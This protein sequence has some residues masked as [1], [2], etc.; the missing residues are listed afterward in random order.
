M[1]VLFSKDFEKLRGISATDDVEKHEFD[2]KKRMDYYNKL[3][4]RYSALRKASFSSDRIVDKE[5][6]AYAERASMWVSVENREGDEASNW[7]Y[8]KPKS[9]KH[10]IL[11]YKCFPKERIS[12][13]CVADRNLIRVLDKYFATGVV[14]VDGKEISNRKTSV[15]GYYKIPRDGDDHAWISRT[16]PVTLYFMEPIDKQTLQD[17]KTITK[18]FRN[19]QKVPDNDLVFLL[20]QVSDADWMSYLPENQ[21]EDIVKQIK[22]VEKYNP[23]LADAIF[24]F[25]SAVGRA[26]LNEKHRIVRLDE[27][28]K[29]SSLFR[30]SAGQYFAI[31][32]AVDECR[33]GISHIKIN[34][35]VKENSL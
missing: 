11:D 19:L 7:N 18:P 27:K 30:V 26:V 22:R 13:N 8:R 4:R 10:K 20:G 5:W 32:E 34:F 16:D 1:A 33:K 14:E 35:S 25:A 2:S 15:N 6:G 12:L 23:E 9:I 17:I 31:K 28:D 24:G 21:P 3:N 29:Y